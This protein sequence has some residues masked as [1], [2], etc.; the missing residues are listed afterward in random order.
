MGGIATVGI[1]GGGLLAFNTGGMK[2]LMHSVISHAGQYRRGRI[3]AANQSLR[4]W[5]EERGWEKFG[6]MMNAALKGDLHKASAHMDEWLHAVT[7]I[8]EKLNNGMTEHQNRMR[9]LMNSQLIDKEI[10]SHFRFS[11][12]NA[13]R[14]ML[15][16]EGVHEQHIERLMQHID[17][18][19]MESMA[20]DPRQQ[21]L[22]L[23]QTGFK[24][25][26][27]QDL[28]DAREINPEHDDWREFFR[29][30]RNMFERAG[31]NAEEFLHTKADEHVLVD[32]VGKIADLRDFRHTFNN[33]FESASTDFTIPL[34]KINPLRMFYVDQFF[35]TATKPA[36]HVTRGRWSN[37]VPVGHNGA[38]GEPLVMIGSNVFK[39]SEPNAPIAENMYMVNAQKGPI[40]RWLRNMSKI[41][42]S[43]FNK[44]EPD[45][46]L[47]TRARYNIQSVLGLG[48]QDEPGGQF[49]FFDM[50]SWGQSFINFFTGKLRMGKYAVNDENLLKHSFGE[51]A[52]YIYMR[53]FKPLSKS[54]SY[55]EFTHQFKAGGDNLKEVTTATLFPY[56]FFER[57]NATLNQVHLGLPNEDLGSAFD[58]FKNLMLKRVLPIVAG[59]ELFNYVNYESENFFGEQMSDRM[60][61]MYANSSV[62]IAS[63]RDRLGITDW[64]KK[65]APLFVGGDQITAFPFVGKFVDLDDTEEETKEYWEEGEDPVRK[66]RWW[67]LGNTAYT[68][69]KIDYFQPNWVRRTLA[70]AKYTDSQYGS[71]EEYFQNSWMPTPRHP[72]APIRHFFTDP[73]HWEEKHY[74]D[75]PYMI[76]G[77]IPELENFP[78]LGPAMNQ[79]LG[80][81]LKPERRMHEEY[82][83]T[84]A[85]P[86]EDEGVPGIGLDGRINAS[87]AITFL[88]M[89][90]HVVPSTAIQNEDHHAISKTLAAYVTASGSVQLLKTDDSDNIK[91]ARS[92]LAERSPA[93]TG[94]F[95]VERLPTQGP[96]PMTVAE[97]VSPGALSQAVGNLHYNISEMGGFY[98]FMG[99]SITGEPFSQKPV[100]QS[101]SDMTSYSRAFWDL[102]IGGYGGDANEIFRR[103][104]PKDRKLN[105]VNP[106]RNRMPDWL[107]GSDYFIDF[108]TGDP[109]RKVKKGEMRL[110][111]EGYEK[112]YGIDSD[113]MLRM[114]L[115][116]SFIG[117]DEATIRKHILKQDAVKDEMFQRKLDYGTA[118]HRRWESEMKRTGVAE[119][120]EQYVKD[121]KTGI[122]GFY[123]VLGDHK[124]VLDYLIQNAA[125]FTVYRRGGS[126]MEGFYTKMKPY[127]MEEENRNALFQTM[128]SESDKA[129]IDPKTRSPRAWDKDEMHFENVQQVNFYANQTGTNWNY[130]I[131]VDRENPDRGIKVFAFERSPEL[132]QY[133]INKVEGVRQQ[134]RQDIDTGSLSRGDLYDPID[135]YR[136][137]ADVAPYSQEFRQMKL[138]LGSMNLD[139][140]ETLEVRKINDQVSQR[141]ERLRLYPYRYTTANLDEQIVTVDQVIDNNTFTTLENP[142]N[143][144]RLAGLRVPTGKDDPVAAKAW[145]VLSH[146]MRPGNKVRIAYDSD[147]LNRVKDDTYKTIQAVVYDSKDRNLNHYLIEND[148]AKEKDNDYTPAAVHARFTPGQLAFGSF[149]E[150]FAHMDTILHTKFLQTRSPLE[151]Y[152]RREVYGK[153]WQ[154]WTDPISDYLI[155]G[156]QNAMVHHPLFAI[157]GGAFIGAA[158]GSLKPSDL[159]YTGEKIMAR[160]GKLVGGVMG[161]TVMASA[162][163]YKNLYEAVKGEAWVPERRR[164]ER[165]V[166]EYFDVLKYIKYNKLFDQYAKAAKDRE[167]VDVKTAIEREEMDGQMRESRRKTLEE[168]KRQ[169]YSSRQNQWPDIQ[170]RLEELG[171]R[172]VD[173]GEATKLLNQE[174]NSLTTHREIR[175]TTPLAAQAILYRQAAKQ[176]MFAY[177]PGDPLA[178]VL[179]A[180]PK[181]ERDYLTPFMAAPEEERERILEVVPSYIKPILQSA[182]GLPV[183][184]KPSLKEYFKRHPL[185]GARW[186]G[187]QENVALDDVKVKYVDRVGLDPSE[188]DIWKDDTLRAKALDVAAPNIR[189]AHETATSFSQKLED[190][191]KSAGLDGV[192]MEIVESESAGIQ[193]DMDIQKDRKK[194]V[195]SLI[196]GQGKFVVG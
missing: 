30:G 165:E 33:I 135:R 151:S 21:E 39:A 142:D 77:G 182:W 190:I 189:G 160:Y 5:S 130:L 25:A 120:T 171:I 169:L 84:T 92:I 105:E 13:V 11:S 154:E 40:A 19:R 119:S 123:D 185:P 70:D 47:L 168:V 60:A 116:A 52:D 96:E 173:R 102:D 87:Q 59:V 179:A 156:I 3:T 111:G 157:G 31:R 109:Y 146:T 2:T 196:N 90:D 53:G 57:L 117:Y 107:P 28:I 55:R 103:F 177:K 15:K 93:F 110:P 20:L 133:S 195:Q 137:L 104:L 126:D 139:E 186:K 37:P 193:L 132:L 115:G 180:L 129:L 106:I 36:Y 147:E 184:E 175:P 141:K 41:S 75:R 188:F 172:A 10:E 101:S 46:P 68:G 183:D 149:W 35:N 159:G 88:P 181:K 114:E 176:T 79:T 161:A 166:E 54:S 191:F 64:A 113:K 81:I 82:W 73:Y 66:G 192:S 100:L 61:K 148:L 187:W 8:R 164:K 76:T 22:K 38:V 128:L 12:Q 67:P 45:A 124:K 125:D 122:G 178:G 145:S 136:I 34:I 72:L 56:A 80:R 69:G 17:T 51:D 74:Y 14:N 194:D 95:R 112:M 26:S 24:Y 32:E 170:K 23:K 86:A 89:A 138:Q 121:P 83:D 158:F 108:E 163:L 127:E 153:D 29:S 49:D 43:K 134:V 48:M 44:P 144:I 162:V 143:P 6:P 58:I 62:E 118:W 174:I 155:P 167:G 85:A 4:R 78:L 131:H 50:T 99:T 65:V 1:L 94:R 16:E 97:S 71:R 18:H 91:Y 7:S 63:F 152:E 98:G 140:A 42:I 27:L 9:S 150:K